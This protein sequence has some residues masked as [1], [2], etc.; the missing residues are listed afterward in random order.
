VPVGDEPSIE[1][2]RKAATG[3]GERRSGS[4]DHEPRRLREPAAHDF[5]GVSLK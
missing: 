4:D 2:Q 5:D 1:E 3:R